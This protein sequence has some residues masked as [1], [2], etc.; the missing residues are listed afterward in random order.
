MT[1]R[2]PN[3]GDSEATG[4]VIARGRYH[5]VDMIWPTLVAFVIGL[6]LGAHVV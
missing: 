3:H 6:W 2:G 5:V 1:V 4:C